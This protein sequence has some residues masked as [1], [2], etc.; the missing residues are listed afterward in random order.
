MKLYSVSK[1]KAK[2]LI[3]KEREKHGYCITETQAKIYLINRK[4]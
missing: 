3:E 2:E 4:K 1:E